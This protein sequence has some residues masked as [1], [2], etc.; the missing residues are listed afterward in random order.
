MKK[1]SNGLTALLYCAIVALTG[2]SQSVKVEQ[3]EIS[4][5]EN[6]GVIANPGQGWLADVNDNNSIVPYGSYYKRFHW[7]DIEPEEGKYNWN[8]IEREIAVA[9]KMGIPFSFRIMCANAHSAVPYASPKWVFEKK[10]AKFK[11]YSWDEKLI[12]PLE[13]DKKFYLMKRIAPYFSDPIFLDVHENFIKALAKKYDGDNRICSIDIGSYGTWGEWHVGCLG[14][15]G[16]S[17]DVMRRYADMYINN[18]KKTTLV[19]MTDAAKTLKYA[20]GEG[21]GSRVGL[22]RDGIGSPWHEENWIGTGKYKANGVD[23]M[24]DV[25]KYKPVIFEWY[26]PYDKMLAKKWSFENA[27]N[28]ILRNHCSLLSFN[29][30]PKLVVGDDKKHL[31]RLNKFL[32]ARIVVSKATISAQGCTLNVRMDCEN[33]GIAQ[34]WLPYELV[35]ELKSDDG[36]TVAKSVAKT[37]PNSWF[38]GK[39]ALNET[40]VI[41]ANLP[42]GK[43]NLSARIANPTKS[44]RDFKLAVKELNKDNSLPLGTISF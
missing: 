23:K 29:L 22:R 7:A 16:S 39:F 26:Y 15:R 8:K 10:G 28:F 30:R 20:I 13:K 5:T 41:P 37:N 36:K 32:G 38:P 42:S 34:V 1:S 17:E 33:K 21:E 12:P 27:V 9:Q 2:C 40:F 18:F 35:F 25:W 43:Y 24:G 3:P 4:F 14:I 6:D 44:F 11:E 31:D 19:F